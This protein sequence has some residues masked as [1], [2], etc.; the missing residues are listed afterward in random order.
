[1]KFLILIFIA[2]GPYLT[3]SK[4]NKSNTR[5]HRLELGVSYTSI[6]F[7]SSKTNNYFNNYY[8]NYFGNIPNPTG[9]HASYNLNKAYSISL[10]FGGYGIFPGNRDKI[11]AITQIN[12]LN[13][14]I[15]LNRKIL[16]HKNFKILAT[17]S[18]SKRWGQEVVLLG[19]YNPSGFCSISDYSEYKSLGIGGGA[20]FNYTMRN[21]F[22][23][24]L[25][26]QYAHYFEKPNLSNN[27]DSEFYSNYKPL[28][29]M[30]IGNLKASVLLF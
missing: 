24:G 7:L 4:A 13:L 29:D 1:M 17:T 19:Y 9:C 3:F 10:N 21:R 5:Q 8:A 30:I 25:E 20:N 27:Y 26:V 23:L 6:Y 14:G 22:I 11:P 12:F 18:L 2:L 15:S 16:Q 28:K